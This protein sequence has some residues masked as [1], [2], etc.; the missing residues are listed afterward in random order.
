QR[1]NKL[2]GEFNNPVYATGIGL[3]LYGAESVVPAERTIFSSDVFS[4]IAGRMNGWFRKIV[5]SK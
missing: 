5:G 4:R 2:R 3:V 1:I